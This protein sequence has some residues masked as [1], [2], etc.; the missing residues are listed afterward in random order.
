MATR[1]KAKAR[2]QP[3]KPARKPIAR[4]KAPAVR[5]TTAKK[6]IVRG[7]ATKKK[8]APR[9]VKTLKAKPV[10]VPSAPAKPVAPA[11]PAAPAPL[12]GEERI[13]VVTHYYGQLSVAIVR[14]ESGRLRL[15]DVVHVVGHS[16]DFRQRVES[17]QIEHQSASEVLAGQE[18][19]LK[20]SEHAREHDVVYKAA[21]S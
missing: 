20:V 21:G 4:K 8:P 15:G 6:R 16:S 18:F 3:K 14:L 7:A 12:A 2:K 1:K 17:M 19:G 9:A 5:K 11:A 10:R 13:G